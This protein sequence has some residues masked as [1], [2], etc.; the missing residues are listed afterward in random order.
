M[1]INPLLS[2][3]QHHPTA[4][5]ALNFIGKLTPAQ[6][7]EVLG[8]LAAVIGTGPQADPDSLRALAGS[9]DAFAC[10]EPG[11]QEGLLNP[12]LDLFKHHFEGAKGAI[13]RHVALG[14]H[15]V[16]VGQEAVPQ[17]QPA[18]VAPVAPAHEVP[19]SSA[20]VQVPLSDE[21]SMLTPEGLFCEALTAFG[22]EF[23][24]AVHQQTSD[25]KNIVVSPLS[26]ALALCMV[27]EGASEATRKEMHRFL[28]FGR[29]GGMD[30]ASVNSHI[31]DYLKGITGE[32]ANVEVSV[33]NGIFTAQDRKLK[34]GFEAAM[35]QVFDAEFGAARPGGEAEINK[36]VSRETKGRISNLLPEGI[37]T[38]LTDL[39][40]VNALYV[41]ADWANKFD[42][43][44]TVPRYFIQADGNKIVVDRMHQKGTFLLR[45]IPLGMILEIPYGNP[46]NHSRFTRFVILP[47]KGSSLDGVIEQLTPE[48][49]DGL[50]SQDDGFNVWPSE[51][52]LGLPKTTFRSHQSVLEALKG[53]PG[54]EHLTSEDADFSEMFVGGAQS[55]LSD[56]IH[57]VDGKD[58][59][60][61]TEFAAATGAVMATLGAPSAPKVFVVDQPYLNLVVDTQTG[62]PLLMT[63]IREPDQSSSRDIF[64]PMK[65]DD[66]IHRAE[67]R[68]GRVPRDGNWLG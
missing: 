7:V 2:A 63:A 45:K 8:G 39:I 37:I 30:I 38:H 18:P 9:C 34:P 32:H 42:E 22:V 12:A 49:I 25:T 36:W 27:Y 65:F 23:L 58:D 51:L 31:R 26:V 20:S 55:F 59:E 43:E 64:A 41:K 14:T 46:H 53:L 19:V 16:A 61:G 28:D 57:A 33:A 6:K 11:L 48:T 10:A 21:P 67:G 40:L 56:V 50:V 15:P 5:G 29:M 35:K 66:E 1:T 68:R 13:S 4:Q 24:K 60:V 3:L 62:I 47:H 44:L 54:F 52:I 17:I